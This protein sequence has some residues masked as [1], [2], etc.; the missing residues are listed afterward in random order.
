M[1]RDEFFEN[2]FNETTPAAED[3]KALRQLAYEERVI[4][5]VFTECGIQ[6]ASWGFMAKNC[7]DATGQVKLNF[8]WFNSAY[9][10]FPCPLI[11]KR[12]PFL[13]KVTLVD[14]FKPTAKNRLVKAI[15]KALIEKN[16]NTVKDNYLLVFPIVKTAFCAH[17]L[18]RSG[19]TEPETGDQRCQI[20]IRV[21]GVKP[22]IIEPLKSFCRAIG[23]DWAS[24]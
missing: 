16:V 20:L 11:G 7:R 8:D 2:L 6:P 19:M 24:M 18:L 14:L 10:G 17:S 13:H 12:I 15:S 1:N 9:P 22:I 23:G 5:R 21:S 3:I 4:K